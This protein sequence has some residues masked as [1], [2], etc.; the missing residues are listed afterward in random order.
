MGPEI[1]VINLKKIWSA[2]C[3][4]FFLNCWCKRKK[5]QKNFVIFVKFVLSLIDDH[6]V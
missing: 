6:R 5:I 4:I 1:I 2:T 3:N